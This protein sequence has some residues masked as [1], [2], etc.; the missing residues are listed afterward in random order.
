MEKKP[1]V[2]YENFHKDYWTKP[3]PSPRIA[4]FF[5]PYD[6]R[7]SVTQTGYTSLAEAQ[8]WTRWRHTRDYGVII[9]RFRLAHYF[10]RGILLA[11]RSCLGLTIE[12]LTKINSLRS[13][14][15]DVSDFL[16]N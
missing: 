7:Q 10:A 1:L 6:L 9:D 8:H 2:D 4:A 12:G 14:I 15:L 11:K 16:G 5:M 13:W 3:P